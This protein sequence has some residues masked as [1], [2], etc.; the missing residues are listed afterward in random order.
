[1]KATIIGNKNDV[2][3]DYI[4]DYEFITAKL[5]EQDYELSNDAFSDITIVFPCKFSNLSEIFK[6]I[7][8]SSNV[9]LFGHKFWNSFIAWLKFNDLN[10]PNIMGI[11]GNIR[12]F[13][14]LMSLHNSSY[15]NI[16]ENLKPLTIIDNDIPDILK[17]I[18]N[19]KNTKY[20]LTRNKDKSVYLEM[21][22]SPNNTDDDTNY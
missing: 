20:K 22:I 18:L 11:A 8:N 2:L 12:Q 17:N 14:K 21:V 5:E 15:S 3:E 10:L 1:M 7:N 19:N 6:K 13:N 9:I 16:D 4:S